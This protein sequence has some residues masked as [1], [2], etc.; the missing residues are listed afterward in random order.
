MNE[1]I[2][3]LKA[4]HLLISQRFI[5]DGWIT[6]YH[7][8]REGEEVDAGIYCLLVKP[9]YLEEYMKGHD[10][11]IH[12]GSEGHPSIITHFKDG[13]SITEYFRFAEDG[14]EPFIYPK[15]F[16]HIKERYVDVSQEFVNYFKLYE[17]VTSK[18]KRS[19]YFIDDSGDEEVVINVS[20]REVRIKLKFMVEYLAVRKIHLSL[21]FD[22][23][24]MTDQASAGAAFVEKD[25]DF[26]G[27]TFNY[28][29]LMRLVPGID[30]GNFQSWIIGKTLLKYDPAKSNNFHF[31][32]NDNANESF[33][34][35]YNDDG[36]E[37]L[38]PCH[39]DEHKFFTPVFFKKEVLNKYY[40]QPE[41]YQVD[42]FHISSSFISLKMDNNHEAYV[43]VFLNDLKML[44]PREQLHWKHHNIARQPGMGLSGSYYDTMI[45]GNWARDS[46]S[47]DVHFKAKYTQFNKKWFAKF[48]W[49]FYKEQVGA[50]QQ[51]F[52]ALHVP[53]EN[54]VTS[55]SDQLLI[56]VKL[57]IDSLNEEMLVK[58]L[59]KVEQEKGIAKL[60]R[61]LDLHH[62]QIP[63]MITF[64]RNLQDLRSGRI[65]HRLSNSNNNAK[66][67]VAYFG[68]TD[69]NYREVALDIF[70]KSLYTL[71]TLTSLFLDPE[72]EDD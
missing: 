64:L 3:S 52:H 66:R 53:S 5:S 65:A 38:A 49:Y 15:W 6:V 34:I 29:H 57:T 8:H 20:E 58:G 42:G 12:G 7:G 16:T 19:Y 47:V 46:D 9:E 37:K 14:M 32:V 71:N 62:R 70:V 59:P 2:F 28:N 54:S 27:E 11:G 10:W 36:S 60:E 4:Q 35:G 72:Q 21:C 61:F 33:I 40:D 63:D 22:F 67:A 51:H 17:K 39:S 50:D 1:E 56:L 41:K 18:Q 48:G 55:F 43:M 23:M 25:E 31:E 13:G 68:L 44:P 26:V 45:M 24:V 30:R 69:E